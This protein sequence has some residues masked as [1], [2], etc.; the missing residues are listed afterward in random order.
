MN[1]EQ[2]LIAF[3]VA[4]LLGITALCGFAIYRANEHAKACNAIGGHIE[5]RNCHTDYIPQTNCLNGVCTTSIV[6]VTNCDSLCISPS[7]LVLN[8]E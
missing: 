2:K 1:E 4:C 3:L 5:S 8:V 7:G 6:P